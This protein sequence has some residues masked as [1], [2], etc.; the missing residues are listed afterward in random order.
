MSRLLRLSAPMALGLLAAGASWGA[1]PE[2]CHTLRHHGR[3]AE[4]QTC[5]QSLAAS[6]DP[7]LRAEGDWGLGMFAEANNEFRTALD[8]SKNSVLY[9][10]RWGGSSMSGLTTPT[11]KCFLR[12]RCR[13][14]ARTRKPFWAWPW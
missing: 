14:T 12:K 10:V 11:R 8:Q 4:A 13:S 3:I 9:R 1:T 7:Y 2:D 6:R 5:Y